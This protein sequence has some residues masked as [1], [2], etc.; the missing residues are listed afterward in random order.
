MEQLFP[1]NLKVATLWFSTSDMGSLNWYLIAAAGSV[2]MLLAVLLRSRQNQRR[3][4]LA[5]FMLVKRRSKLRRRLKKLLGN[6]EL[7]ATRAA[8]SEGI[9]LNVSSSSLEALEAAIKRAEADRERWQR[10]R[11]ASKCTAKTPVKTSQG[12]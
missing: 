6:D 3:Q 7:K 12:E 10:Y 8:Q 9:R 4:Q 2:V 5:T 11:P 1:K